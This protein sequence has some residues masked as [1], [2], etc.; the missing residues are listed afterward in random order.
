MASLPVVSQPAHRCAALIDHLAR[1]MRMRAETVLTPLGLRPRH[2]VALTMLRDHAESTQQSLSTLLQIDRTNLV[3]LLNELESWGLIERRR[4]AED[5]RRH[6]VHLTQPGA[7]RLAQAEFALAAVEDEILVSL[8][9]DQ[10][11]TLYQLLQ[12]AGNRQRP[13]CAGAMAEIDC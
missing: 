3:G 6:T 9:G 10:R 1:R 12:I 4:S 8:D 11:E 7:E 5:R 13:D 2:L